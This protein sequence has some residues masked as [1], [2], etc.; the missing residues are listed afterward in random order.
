MREH[1]F[2][3]QL[4]GTR[5]RLPLFLCWECHADREVTRRPTGRLYI[6]VG[7]AEFTSDVIKAASGRRR[8]KR[9]TPCW[10]CAPWLLSTKKE[11]LIILLNSLLNL[12]SSY[13]MWVGQNSFL[14]LVVQKENHNKDHCLCS[15]SFFAFPFFFFSLCNCCSYQCLFHKKNKYEQ[16][17]EHCRICTYDLDQ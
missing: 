8:K 3:D 6:F 16:T 1:C 12:Q 5:F 11:M 9:R 2:V 17:E 14:F 4:C 7:E 13:T 15:P 10:W